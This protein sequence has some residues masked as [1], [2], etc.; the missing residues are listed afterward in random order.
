MC[1]VTDMETAMETLHM[2]NTYLPDTLVESEI[3]KRV[4]K[5]QMNTIIPEMFGKLVDR[6]ENRNNVVINQLQVAYQLDDIEQF[7]AL[8]YEI[9][10]NCAFIEGNDE[11]DHLTCNNYTTNWSEKDDDDFDIIRDLPLLLDEEDEYELSTQEYMLYYIYM[12]F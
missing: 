7:S 11:D 1:A 6:L 4:H 5:S 12:D 9:S 3:M 2:V 10:Y 8:R